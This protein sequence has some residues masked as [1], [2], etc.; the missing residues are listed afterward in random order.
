[1]TIN[2]IW[3]TTLIPFGIAQQMLACAGVREDMFVRNA[4]SCA[5]YYRCRGQIGEPDSC[6]GAYMFD[7]ISQTCNER[8]EVDCR[9]CSPFGIQNLE[10]S[11]DRKRYYACVA[12]ARTHRTCAAGL[13]FD[14][15]IGDC[16]MESVVPNKVADNFGEANHKLLLTTIFFSIF[17]GLIMHNRLLKEA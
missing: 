7:P 5:A 2:L 14:T 15:R 16:N 3:L 9:Q 10:D 11:D 13:V 8:Q 12:G 4:E 1:M 17:L 6:P